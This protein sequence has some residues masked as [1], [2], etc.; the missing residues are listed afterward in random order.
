M[1]LDLHQFTLTFPTYGDVHTNI[2]ELAKERYEDDEITVSVYTDYEKK[3]RVT[4]SMMDSP[5][6]QYISCFFFECCKSMTV[7]TNVYVV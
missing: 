5:V 3:S 4:V 6:P 2:Q 7:I 1:I